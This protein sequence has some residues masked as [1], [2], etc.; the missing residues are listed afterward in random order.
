MEVSNVFLFNH[1]SYKTNS[2]FPGLYGKTINKN[3]FLYLKNYA[4]PDVSWLKGI[5]REIDQY[6]KFFEILVYR[7][8]NIENDLADIRQAIKI[9]K[10]HWIADYTS[11]FS[12]FNP[13][14][15]GGLGWID[16]EINEY[17]NIS[18]NGELPPVFDW[19]NVT[20]TNW[21]T[22]VKNQG[23]CGS[24]T[25]FAILSALE[26]VV[27][28][29]IGKPC[30]CDLSEAHLF[31]C[32]GGDCSR[33][34]KLSKASEYI[35]MFG[36][37][38]EECFPYNDCYKGCGHS[39]TNWEERAIKV[40]TMNS[41]SPIFDNIRNALLKF[42][43]LVTCMN[44]FEDL[45]SYKE[46]IYQHVWGDFCG[47]HSVTIMG[48]N[49]EEGYWICKNSWGTEWG[50][51]GWFNIRYGQCAI[52]DPVFY[53]SGVT[54]NIQPFL[55]SNPKPYDGSVATNHNITL[56]WDCSDPEGDDIYYDIY[57]G[58]GDNIKESD[59]IV[60]NYKDTYYSVKNLEKNTT[61]SWKIVAKDQYGARTV[62]PL[63]QFKVPEGLPPK[64]SIIKP[65]PGYIYYY[66]VTIPFFPSFNPLPIVIGKTKVN[67]E[68]VD[69]S[70]I[71][72]VEFY[73]ND[74]LRFTAEKT[75]YTWNW[76]EKSIVYG[77]FELKVTAYDIYGNSA[78]KKMGIKFVNLSPFN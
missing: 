5:T 61:Y 69:S 2:N 43:P 13:W 49:N 56:Q 28:I 62:G 15:K 9:N 52:G 36:V 25:A 66:A 50:E 38:D 41:I 19:R 3:N 37:P 16:E 26:S 42:G 20:G 72:R 17:E 30:G 58:K 68:A 67:V 32:A 7:G 40:S 77:I 10:A 71:D 48:Y 51:D 46:G 57:L 1:S 47:R 64:I 65:A 34:L 35:R 54:G 45:Y 73:I 78:S 59:L 55:P 18:F 14:E 39:Q 33:G 21:M 22:P 24:C 29:H 31:S 6:K 76:N 75:P 74:H 70:G 27:Q 63:W 8:K 12:P 23:E 4:L 53:L 11:V 44:V 60:F